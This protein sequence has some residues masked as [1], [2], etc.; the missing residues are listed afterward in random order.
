MRQVIFLS[1]RPGLEFES[2]AL[3][4]ETLCSLTLWGV[5]QTLNFMMKEFS[6]ERDPQSVTGLEM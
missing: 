6:K 3:A 1:S 4:L 5:Q 2:W